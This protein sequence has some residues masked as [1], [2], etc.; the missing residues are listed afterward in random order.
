MRKENIERILIRMKRKFVGDLDALPRAH[1]FTRALQ[2]FDKSLA[3]FE[4]NPHRRPM[5][6][7][8]EE[9]FQEEG[10]KR[11]MSR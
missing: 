6:E 3:K 1:L 8:Y 2:N 9:Q 11:E 7:A 5:R 4:F 10:N